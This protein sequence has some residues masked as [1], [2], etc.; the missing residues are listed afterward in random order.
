MNERCESANIN[1]A[2]QQVMNIQRWQTKEEKYLYTNTS[3]LFILF[4]YQWT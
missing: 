4:Y 2:L 1:N 3:Y